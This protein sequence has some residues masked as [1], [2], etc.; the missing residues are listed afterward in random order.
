EPGPTSCTCS[1]RLITSSMANLT[2]RIPAGRFRWRTTDR[3]RFP[4]GDVSG[5]GL[6][7]VQRHDE[8]SQRSTVGPQRVCRVLG[9][10]AARVEK[11]ISAGVEDVD[12][13]ELELHSGRAAGKPLVVGAAQRKGHASRAEITSHGNRR[14]GSPQREKPE[15]PLRSE[16]GARFT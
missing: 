11:A 5:V 3:A 15:A 2:G 1:T 10:I 8:S 12:S 7:A 6:G 14:A 13:V 16:A 4:A 9:M